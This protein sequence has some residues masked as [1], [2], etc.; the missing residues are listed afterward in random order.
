MNTPTKTPAT[1]VQVIRKGLLPSHTYIHP[2]PPPPPP[3]HT[4][5]FLPEVPDNR[6]SQ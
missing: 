4:H 3:T 6:N 2:P 5:T 1:I